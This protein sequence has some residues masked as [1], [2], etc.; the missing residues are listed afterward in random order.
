M[1]AFQKASALDPKDSV[2]VC[3]IGYVFEKMGRQDAALRYYGKALKMNP[4][5]D[6]A[7]RLMAGV[8]PND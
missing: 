1:T 6:M 8:N 7:T 3:M 5:D 4:G 2:S